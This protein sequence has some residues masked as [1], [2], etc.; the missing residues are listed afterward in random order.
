MLPLGM[1]ARY[2]YGAFSRLPKDEISKTYMNLLK[3]LEKNVNGDMLKYE[4]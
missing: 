1:M 3:P 4:L 2:G